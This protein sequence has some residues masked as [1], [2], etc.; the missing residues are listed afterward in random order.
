MMKAEK[1]NSYKKMGLVMLA[2]AFAGGVM[3]YLGV[4]LLG[5]RKEEIEGGMIFLLREI[6]QMQFPILIG[7]TVLSA[8]Y[9]E[10][11]IKK[12]K[13][14]GGKLKENEDEACD[15]WE[16]E[17]ERVGAQGMLVNILSQILC[18]LVLSA[19]F[20]IRYIEDDHSWNMLA[21]CIIFLV[22]Y[23][24]DGFWQVRYVKL[25][26][27]NHPE[28]KGD[29]ASPKFQ[30]QWIESCDEAEKEMIYQSAYKSYIKVNQSIPYLLLITMLAHLFFCSCEIKK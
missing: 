7:I 26:Q 1:I 17:E 15:K 20:S 2:A 11:N 13:T 16:Y 10:W 14:I 24:Y 19:G 22:C 29:P 21:S 25:A 28:K 30:K 3:G 8:I 12:L 18:I 5:G 4:S 9:G 23:I 27:I 6:R